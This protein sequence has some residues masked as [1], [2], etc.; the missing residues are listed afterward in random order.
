[1]S[2]HFG[3]L[4]GVEIDIDDTIVHADTEMK[5]VCNLNSVLDRCKKMNLTLHKAKCVFKNKEVTYLGHKLT[6]EGI[7]PD[8]GKVRAIKEMSAPTD[9]KGVER[10]LGRVHYL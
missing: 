2:Q 5:H 6:Q 9:K 3:D 10:L 7:K 8:D 1:M 4:E